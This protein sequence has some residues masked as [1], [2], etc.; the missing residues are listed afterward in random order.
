MHR[1]KSC[2]STA[3]WLAM[4]RKS[5]TDA[6]ASNAVSIEQ[7]DAQSD[8]PPDVEQLGRS[9]WTLLH[10]MTAVY[11]KTAPPAT[12][13]KTRSFLTLFSELYPCWVCADDFR[14]WMA[15]PSNE[16]QLTGREEFG[17]WMCRAHN[18]VNEKLGKPEFDCLRWKE[19][20]KDGW[21]DGRCD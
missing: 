5:D 14:D 18:A 2:T 21:K 12:Q 10:T 15:E 13:S 3:S 19:R 8:C 17:F 1:C 6:P 16:P 7:S 20:W 11:P 4:M 9:T